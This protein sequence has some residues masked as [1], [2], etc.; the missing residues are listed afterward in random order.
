MSFDIDTWHP[1][2]AFAFMLTPLVIGLSGVA[3]IAYTTYRFYDEVSSAFPNSR[4][5]KNTHRM[6]AGSNFI[7]RWLQVSSTGSFVLFPN[8]HIK[9]GDLDPLEV[10]AFP[11]CIKRLITV[12]HSLMLVG[13]VWLILAVG[14]LK[15]TES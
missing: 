10:Q 4:A 13:S 1:G 9:R 12:G 8:G 6:W 15:L 5:V 3:V 11:P 14:L 7:S 2:L